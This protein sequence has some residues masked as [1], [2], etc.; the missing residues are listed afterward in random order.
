MATWATPNVFVAVTRGLA[1]R[2]GDRIVAR[3]ESQGV[4]HWFD[5]ELSWV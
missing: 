4:K 5:E 2:E 3:F 1:K